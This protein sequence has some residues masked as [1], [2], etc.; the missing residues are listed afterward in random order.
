[1]LSQLTMTTEKIW[2]KK[3]G[4]ERGLKNQQKKITQSQEE[5]ND[6]MEIKFEVNK[7]LEW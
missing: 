7:E 2:R 6:K 3:N 5:N 4:T 1:M